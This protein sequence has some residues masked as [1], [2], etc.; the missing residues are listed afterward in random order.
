[1]TLQASGFEL[2]AMLP[3]GQLRQIGGLPAQGQSEAGHDGVA[4]EIHVRTQLVAGL[5]IVVLGVVVGLL[6]AP[7]AGVSLVFHAFVNGERRNTYPCQA[8]MIGAVVVP[9]LGM[10]VGNHGQSASLFRLL[11]TG[12]KTAVP[13]T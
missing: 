2:V 8:E 13:S 7:L 1:M 4:T 12:I 11:P 3:R 10:R 6:Q 5:M 9:G